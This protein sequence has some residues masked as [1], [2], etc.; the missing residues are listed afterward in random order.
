MAKMQVIDY[1]NASILIAFAM[2]LR[3]RW[4]YSPWPYKYRSPRFPCSQK[5]IALAIRSS[6]DATN[7]ENFLDLSEY[8]LDSKEKKKCT[9]KY[10]CT[11]L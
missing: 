8:E 3:P 4:V 10:E 11:Y 9:T 7:S 6:L 2:T 1:P 5:S